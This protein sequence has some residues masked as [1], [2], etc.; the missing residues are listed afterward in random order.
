MNS[1]LGVMGYDCKK[2]LEAATHVC[3]KVSAI[4]E[5]FSCHIVE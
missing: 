1:I 2:E 4:S 3:L 5:R